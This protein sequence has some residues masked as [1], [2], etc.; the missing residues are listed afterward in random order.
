MIDFLEFLYF[1]FTLQWWFSSWPSEEEEVEQKVAYK[2]EEGPT[3][4]NSVA[5]LF[6]DVIVIF[7]FGN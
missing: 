1:T 3:K 4:G 7:L 6:S 5:L 2:N